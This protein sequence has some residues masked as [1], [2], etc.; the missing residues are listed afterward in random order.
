MFACSLAD[1]HIVPNPLS[2]ITQTI[3][4]NPSRE[5]CKLW[6][7]SQTQTHYWC[8]FDPDI[9]WSSLIV[10][11]QSQIQDEGPVSTYPET[12]RSKSQYLTWKATDVPLLTC[13]R[14]PRCS[15]STCA[16]E[17]PELSVLSKGSPL[18]LLEIQLSSWDRK[19]LD[20]HKKWITKNTRDTSYKEVWEGLRLNQA[21][22]SLLQF[23]KNSGLCTLIRC[24]QS[25]V[26]SA[27]LNVIASFHGFLCHLVKRGGS[28]ICAA[29]SHYWLDKWS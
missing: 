6:R 29:I 14:Y 19:A 5:Y 3:S 17:P 22:C 18:R 16:S 1:C 20:F 4:E 2:C 12:Q 21:E 10:W 24:W 27:L 8:L 23:P 13:R 7:T 25:N 11:C 26:T 15:L 9:W 28:I